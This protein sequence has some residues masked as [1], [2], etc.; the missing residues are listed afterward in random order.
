VTLLAPVEELEGLM[1]TIVLPI[2]S[3]VTGFGF[4]ERADAGPPDVGHWYQG[5]CRSSIV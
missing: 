3:Q 5:P 4:E 2:G 1:A